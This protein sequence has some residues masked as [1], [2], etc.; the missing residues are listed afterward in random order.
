MSHTHP[1]RPPAATILFAIVVF[2]GVACIA[3]GYVIFGVYAASQ[4]HR[5]DDLRQ[6]VADKNKLVAQ[7]DA[8]L[9]DLL[10][11]YASLAKDCQDASCTTTAPSPEI[12]REFIQGTPGQAG[13]AGHTPTTAEVISAIEAYCAAQGGCS[14]QA[15]ASGQN[16]TNGADGAPG[17][18]G[19]S[20]PAGPQGD[21]G[22]AGAD[23]RGITAVTCV[24]EDDLFTTAFRFTY[25]DGT[26]QDVAA[27]C[28]PN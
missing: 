19:P 11:K 14:G 1:R 20:G 12:I 10:E 8:Q 6:T 22:P 28:I 24:L 4:Q 9:S 27:S 18:E 2:V 5:A 26:S 15:G 3:A 25:T 21:Q 7:K 17:A 23:G 16:G 13:Q